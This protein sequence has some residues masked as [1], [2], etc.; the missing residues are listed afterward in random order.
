M[1]FSPSP[2]FEKGKGEEKQ[3]FQKR[4]AELTNIRISHRPIANGYFFKKYA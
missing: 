2:P 1:V 3:E 4:T